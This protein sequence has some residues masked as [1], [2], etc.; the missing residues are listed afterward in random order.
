MDVIKT[1]M[2]VQDERA[3]ATMRECAW[4]L[5]SKRGWRA[6]WKGVKVR[7]VYAG[8]ISLLFFY[9]YEKSIAYF[10]HNYK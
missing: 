3:Y 2:M 7:M 10:S 8:S 5:Y 4:D 1:N 9:G 6:F